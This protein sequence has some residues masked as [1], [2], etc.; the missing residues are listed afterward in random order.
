[1][2]NC[3]LEKVTEGYSDWYHSEAW[4]RFPIHLP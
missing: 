4:V 1:L 2:N 3:D